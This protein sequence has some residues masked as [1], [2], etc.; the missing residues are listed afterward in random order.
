MDQNGSSKSRIKSGRKLHCFISLSLCVNIRVYEIFDVLLHWIS[1]ALSMRIFSINMFTSA[2]MIFEHLTANVT[3]LPSQ[4]GQNSVYFLG[5]E[6][7]GQPL[8]CRQ[9]KHA[10]VSLIQPSPVVCELRS[11]MCDMPMLGLTSL[12]RK[13]Q[14]PL[15]IISHYFAVSLPLVYELVGPD[16]LM[17]KPTEPC[18][19]LFLERLLHKENTD[20]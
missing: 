6:P 19:N 9:V 14:Q 13:F 8:L 16:M 11:F 4:M 12:P 1:K 15:T 2:G 3:Y 17:V 7:L 10:I 20:F 18:F 5:S